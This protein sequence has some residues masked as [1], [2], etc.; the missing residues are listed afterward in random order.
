MNLAN[1][2]GSPDLIRTI[3]LHADSHGVTT[4]TPSRRSNVVPWSTQFSA[5]Y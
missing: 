4:E 2:I 5:S 1:P 3:Y